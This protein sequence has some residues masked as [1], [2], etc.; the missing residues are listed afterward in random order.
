VP[1]DDESPRAW[2]RQDSR[3]SR[4]AHTAAR[5]MTVIHLNLAA[6]ARQIQPPVA[7]AQ[8]V[9]DIPQEPSG[10]QPRVALLA[11]LDRAGL[12][13][14]V[15]HALTGMPGVGKTQLAAGYARAKLT[16]GWRLV[17]WVGAVDSVNLATGLAA[18]AEAI[19]LRGQGGADPGR[20]VRHWLE[21]DG[22]RCLVVF[23]NVT[24]ADVLRPYIPAVGA[25]QVLVTSSQQ[26]VADLGTS[27]GVEV[28]SPSEALAFLQDRTG[29]ADPAGAEALAAEL[30]F[31]PLALAQAAAVIARQRL[32]YDTYLERLRGL[33]VQEYLTRGPGQPYPH[34]VAE[35]VLLSLE[36]VRIGDTGPVCSSVLQFMGVLSEDGVHRDLLHAAV[37]EG[38]LANRRSGIMLAE[39]AVDEALGRLA[40]QSL[41]TFSMDGRAVAAHRL[42]LRVVR[43]SLPQHE[44]L[45]TVVRAAGVLEA[46]AR[47]LVGSQDRR[48]IRDI[49]DQVTALRRAAA[50]FPAASGVLDAILLTLRFWALYHLNEL[51]DSAQQAI[52]VGE[53]LTDDFERLL[54]PDHPDTLSSRNNLA[55]AYQAAGR[56]GQA[57]G[58]HEQILADRERV[59]GPDHPDTLSS[60]N[61]LANAYQE[62]GQAAEAIPLHERTLAALER[63]VGP[64]HPDTLS[65]RNNLANAYQEAGQGAEAIPLHEQTLA[66]RQRVLGPDHPDT[67]SSRNNLA[68]AYRTSGRAA[69]ATP[70]H[71]QSLAALERV[72]GPDHPYTLSSRT[73]LANAYQEAGR[74]A[75]A[76]PLHERTL[77]DR[78]RVLGPDHPDTLSSRN[79]LANAYQEAGRAAEAIR[80]H[81]R[82]LAALERVLGPDHPYTLSSRTNLANAYQEAGGAAEAIPLREDAHTAFEW[83][84]GRPDTLSTRSNLANPY[85]ETSAVVGMSGGDDITTNTSAPQR[86]A[87]WSDDDQ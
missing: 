4:D 45:A 85:H 79:N 37:H 23:D 27:V 61:N 28:F 56:T 33:P 38:V 8:V 30:G 19:G 66:D 68:E 51:G 54:G 70:V 11:E 17:A 5:D 26:S 80:L 57:L 87:H 67:L 50:W 14:P 77:A 47:T 29:L 15:V 52:A 24:D 69:E 59:L 65:S 71:Q 55:N 75:E 3:A 53:P 83:A 49:P 25:A 40:G 74:A 42:V 44:R 13:A 63:V 48:A 78:E 73:N 81:E 62:A 86:P 84:R 31:L 32:G 35:A 58:V 6:D 46:R 12:G 82:T 21:A 22:R 2:I 36:A 16:A 7:S 64:D 20:A 60:R 10:F 34:G 9:G 18:V 1:G 76:I 72:L 39:A 43:D 41:L